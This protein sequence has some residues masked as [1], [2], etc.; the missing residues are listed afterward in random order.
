LAFRVFQHVDAWTGAKLQ[1][2]ATCATAKPSLLWTSALGLIPD[3]GGKR[4]QALRHPS[5]PCWR[6]A[7]DDPT[8]FTGD[9]GVFLRDCGNVVTPGPVP[10][11]TGQMV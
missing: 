11:E 4:C 8:G 3:A 1:V 9:D 6:G 7:Q 2:K 5:V 10:V